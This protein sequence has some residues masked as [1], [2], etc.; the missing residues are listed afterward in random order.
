MGYI[1]K[2]KITNFQS[3]RDTEIIF[4]EGLTVILG[5]TDQG[6]SAIIRALKWV[7]YNEPRGT[8]F[9]SVGSNMCR[10][11][12]EMDDGTIITRE[13]TH[14]RNR[15]IL[16][17]DGKKQIFEGFGNTV[18]LEIIKAHGIPKIYLDNDSNCAVNLAEQLDGPFLLSENA[19]IRAKVL[20]RLIGIHIID[21]AQRLTM[22]DLSDAEQRS[23]SIKNELEEIKVKLKEYEDL[24]L[25]EQKIHSLQQILQ[26]LKDKN[27]LYKKLTNIKNLLE[28][29]NEE[30][31]TLKAILK[32]LES[33][34]EIEVILG[35]IEYAL[36]L[37]ILLSECRSK[38]KVI[39]KEMYKEKT[40]IEKTSKLEEALFSHNQALVL[41]EELKKLLHVRES[42][43]KIDVEMSALRNVF[44]KTKDLNKSVSLIQRLEA[45]YTK[46]GELNKVKNRKIKV[47]AQIN[48]LSQDLQKYKYIEKVDDCINELTSLYSKLSNLTTLKQALNEV[49]SLISKGQ[50]YLAQNYRELAFFASRYGALLRKLSKCPTCMNPI[51]DTRAEQIAAEILK[52]G[53]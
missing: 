9:I 11:S 47:E 18:P 10:V 30:I 43:L 21:A 46:L 4:D 1:K 50:A 15:Y 39:E 36:K 31:K 12:L 6:K 51:D 27:L 34:S 17:K 52:S 38:L 26:K 49:E 7:L 25:L 42:L 23:K 44:E 53:G 35:K 28:S 8:D 2:L 29:C 22:K 20:G 41:L 48:Q 16:E 40:K 32:K 37:K 45:S 5:A 19:S 33:V 13:R 24:P 14:N 3:H